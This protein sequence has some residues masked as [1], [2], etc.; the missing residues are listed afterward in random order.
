MQDKV[1]SSIL[2]GITSVN[3]RLFVTLLTSFWHFCDD[4]FSNWTFYFFKTIFRFWTKRRVAFWTTTQS[5]QHSRLWSAR[6]QKSPRRPKRPSPS[7][8]RSRRLVSSTCRWPRPAAQYT[9]RLTTFTRSITSISS[10]CP[11]SSKSSTA[12]SSITQVRRHPSRKWKV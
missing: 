11:S 5:S 12:C 9:L 10:R 6:P 8:R 1:I 3:R 7:W 2:C 4:N